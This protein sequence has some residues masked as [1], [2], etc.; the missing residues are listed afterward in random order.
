MARRRFA[1]VGP[2]II[3]IIPAAEGTEI[4]R[5][6]ARSYDVI[7]WGLRSDGCVLA[8]VRLDDNGAELV[9]VDVEAP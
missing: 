8:M 5:F 2:K 6:P 4:N 1:G 9:P 3:Q 7:C